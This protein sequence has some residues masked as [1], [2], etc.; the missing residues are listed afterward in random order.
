MD[1]T[2][3]M[4]PNIFLGVSDGSAQYRKWYYE[5]IVDQ[6]VPFVTAEATHLRVGWA[7]T[8]GYAPYPSGG[9]GWGGN[10]VGDDL[11]SY[12]FD[13]LH[14]WVRFLLGGRHGEFKFLPPPGYAPCYEAVLP[15]EKLK[16]EASQDQTAARHLLGPTITLSQAAFTPTPVDTSQIVLP[17]HL[18]RIREKLAENIHELWVMNKI[19]LGWTFGAVRD[20]NKR[21][22]PCLVEFSKL[23]EQERSYNLQMSLETLKTLLALGCHV[24]LADEHAVEKVKSMK[25]SPTKPWWTNWLKMHTT[26]GQETASAR[27]GPMASNR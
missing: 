24:G 15:R 7:N 10:G 27:A 6:A 19:E 16:L 2:T 3:S 1:A 22:H 12:G 5:L 8:N 13:G 26:S 18:E 17:P 25:L 11:Y 14:L 23:P 21:Q 9:E 4:H 20:D